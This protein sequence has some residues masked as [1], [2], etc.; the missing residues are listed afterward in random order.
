MLKPVLHRGRSSVSSFKLHYILLSLRSS[1][2]CLRFLSPRSVYC[3]FPSVKCPEGSSYAR[4]DQAIWPSFSLLR[5]G[6]SCLSSLYVILFNF[7]HDRSNWSSPSF[8]SSTFQNSPGISDILSEVSKFQQHTKSFPI[9]SILI[10]SSSNLSPI[11][12]WKVFFLL[13]VAFA[14]AILYLISHVYILHY[15][16]SCY[17]NSW[18]IPYRLFVLDL[19]LSVTKMATLSFQLP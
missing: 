17:P 18:N 4:C 12:W 6:Y 5:V 8:C 1:S 3:I 2:N 11:C 7:S 16:L 19:S 15:L 13:N 9:I 10:V 14:T